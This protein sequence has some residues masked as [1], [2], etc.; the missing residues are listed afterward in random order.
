MYASANHEKISLKKDLK[1][2]SDPVAAATGSD[3]V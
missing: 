2:R 3:F 1:V